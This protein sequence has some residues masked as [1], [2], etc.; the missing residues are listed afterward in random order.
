MLHSE[1]L[2][3]SKKLNHFIQYVHTA[4]TETSDLK[5]LI[6]QLTHPFTEILSEDFIPESFMDPTLD[7]FSQYLLYRSLSPE[8]SLMAMLVPPNVSTPIHDHLAWGLV[9]VYQGQQKETVYSIKQVSDS[10]QPIT[11]E[12]T[13]FL[14]KGDVTVIMPPE[15]DIHMIET[16]SDIPSVSL[17]LLGND[18]G[19][20]ERHTYNP[21]TGDVTSFRSGYVNAMCES[22]RDDKPAQTTVPPWPSLG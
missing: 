18:I 17:H 5:T 22:I 7:N 4:I 16:I 8:F 9:G 14:Y 15:N 1:Q 20:K 11:L 21:K 3:D 13:N 2:L 12:N 10:Q 6:S 19:C